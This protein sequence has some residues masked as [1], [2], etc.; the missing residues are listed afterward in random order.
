MRSVVADS[1]ANGRGGNEASSRS[2]RILAVLRALNMDR[3]TEGLFRCALEGGHTVHVALEQ[4]K[5]RAG[6]T[7]GE[8][9]LFDGLAREYERFSYS[10]LPPRK[11]LWLHTATRL[12]SAIDLLR[13]FEPEFAQAED[14]RAR[15]LG[16]A[17]WYARLLAFLGVLRVARLRRAIERSWRAVENRM[18]ISEH[19]L[20][21]IRE[22]D[23]DVLLVSPLVE[24]GSPQGDHLRAAD[25]LGIP[26]VLV[27]AS[28]DNL[29]TKGVIRDV[30]ELTIVWNED[31]VREA[32]DLHGLPADR[33]VA[34]G[35]HS[36]DHWF[37]WKPSTAA[38]DFNAKVGLARDRPFLLYVCSSGFI[39]GDAEVGFV[40]EWAD[41]LGASGDPEL[42]SLGVIV[43]PHPQNFTSWRDADLDEPG[44]IAVW[45]RGGVAPT[46]HQSK[47]D[48]FDS[49]YHA[50]AVVG[51][52]TTALVDSA[53]V[54][55]PVFTVVSDDFRGTQSG[56]LHFSYLAREDGDGLL[57]V[58]ESWQEHFAQL[59][60]ALRSP[61]RHREQIEGFLKGFVRPHGIDR[62]AA[63]LA[64]DA[65]TRTA[66]DE[67]EPVTKRG[68][69]RWV[70]GAV[71][72]ALG[73]MHAELQRLRK[74]VLRWRRKRSRRR[75]RRIQRHEHRHLDRKAARSAQRA[76]VAKPDKPGREERVKAKAERA[77][78]KRLRAAERAGT[79]VVDGGG[80]THGSQHE[81]AEARERESAEK[82]AS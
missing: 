67:K 55:R 24:G 27:V 75:E 8:Q 31:Q 45:P 72:S 58:A 36:H 17:P 76:K 70:V 21:M 68:P 59:G 46:G 81:D 65:I 62:P 63:P 40:R 6:R 49:L 26:T 50:E 12:R 69:A 16:N 73:L 30:P 5:D 41:R 32:T 29:T 11:E 20:A 28:W 10:M 44:R 77:A 4:K 3:I 74:R 18:P 60:A 61:D 80:Q 51:L 34:T 38:S 53:I 23:P 79:Q 33:V 47:V 71:A 13:Y 7:E 57:N 1:G 25:R 43:R 37:T 39:A 52:N 64:L 35:A 14:L 56:T 22:C 82:S 78:E 42:E 19:C 66:L 9:S 48:Y 15:A 54:R 2:L